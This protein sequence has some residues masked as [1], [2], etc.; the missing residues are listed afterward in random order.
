MQDEAEAFSQYEALAGNLG[1][2]EVAENAA[3]ASKCLAEALE[4]AADTV[5][6]T[7]RVQAESAHVHEHEH[8]H[9]HT[10]THSHPHDHPTGGD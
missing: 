6:A 3:S 8:T 10:H 4:K 9:E 2:D 1:W 7:V 5:E